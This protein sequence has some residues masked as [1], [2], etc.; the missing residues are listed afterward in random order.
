MQ[1]LKAAVVVKVCKIQSHEHE[2]D[3]VLACGSLL[4]CQKRVEVTLF[5]AL[6]EL[7]FTVDMDGDDDDDDDSDIMPRQKRPK[8]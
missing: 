8:R 1:G 5:R 7:I 6:W 4:V 3:T 2:P